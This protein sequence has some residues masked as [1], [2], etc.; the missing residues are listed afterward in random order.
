M[1]RPVVEFLDPDG[2]YALVQPF[3][4]VRG[5]VLSSNVL[6]KGH[7]L[8]KDEK[9][10]WSEAA[11]DL[12]GFTRLGPSDFLPEGE[13]WLEPAGEG[14]ELTQWLED[15]LG[16]SREELILDPLLAQES[17][18]PGP[19]RPEQGAGEDPVSLLLRLVRHNRKLHVRKEGGSCWVASCRCPAFQVQGDR[20]RARLHKLARAALLERKLPSL[21]RILVALRES[22]GRRVDAA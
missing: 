10:S 16:S 22:F 11:E 1:T 20:L 4:E 14:R 7:V 2:S 5:R 9:L 18:P 19:A 12:G 21:S 13:A 3:D 8:H 6:P 15:P 17:P